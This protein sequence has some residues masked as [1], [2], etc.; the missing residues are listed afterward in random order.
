MNAIRF[1]QSGAINGEAMNRLAQ[2]LKSNGSIRIQRQNPR[3]LLAERY[4]AGLLSAAELD[5]MAG[6][7]KP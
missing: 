5:A 6:F 2:W 4:P 1:T 7:F 3:Q